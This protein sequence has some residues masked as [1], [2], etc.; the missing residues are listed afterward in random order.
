MENSKPIKTVEQPM[1]QQETQ[2]SVSAPPPGAVP[3]KLIKTSP[4]LHITKQT[5]SSQMKKQLIPEQSLH[6]GAISAVAYASAYA[7]FTA[8]VS[9]NIGK[10]HSKA[11]PTKTKISKKPTKKI[12]QNDQ[13]IEVPKLSEEIIM[14]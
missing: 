6:T 1:S 8:S 13:E 4:K 7:K 2:K 3:F 9:E 11:I 5:Q 12:T 14:S 10:K